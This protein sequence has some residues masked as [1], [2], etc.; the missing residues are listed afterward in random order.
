[1]NEEK[2]PLDTVSWEKQISWVFLQKTDDNTNRTMGCL[3]IILKHR[4]KNLEILLLYS[5]LAGMK[6]TVW[7]NHHA[8]KEALNLANTIDKH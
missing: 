3:P 6:Y 8:L 1:M 4:K 7:T 5:H 2:Y